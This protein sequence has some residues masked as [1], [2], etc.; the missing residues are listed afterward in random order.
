MGTR[1]LLILSAAW[2][3]SGECVKVGP[4]QFGRIEVSAFSILGDRL[5]TLDIDLIEAGTQK[6]LKSLLNGAVATKI[7]YGTYL[8]RVSA[9]GFRRSE[10]EIHLDQPDLSVRIQLSVSI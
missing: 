5:P 6:S 7:P 8:V 3:C 10:R 4:A 1:L 2:L 9:P